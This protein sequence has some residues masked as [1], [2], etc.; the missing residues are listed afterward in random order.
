MNKHLKPG[1]IYREE[2]IK[3]EELA[4]INIYKEDLEKSGNLDKLLKGEK[5]EVINLHLM[6]L[7][8]MLTWMPPCKWFSREKHRLSKLS[9]SHPIM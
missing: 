8:W 1:H 6:L 4:A 7:G 5:T 9:V 3:W 2:D